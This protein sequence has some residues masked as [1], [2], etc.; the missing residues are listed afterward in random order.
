MNQTA[1]QHVAAQESDRPRRVIENIF[2]DNDMPEERTRLEEWLRCAFSPQQFM[3]RQM[4][5]IP[6]L[7]YN[8]LLLTA[9]ASVLSSD[10]WPD[11]DDR[12]NPYNAMEERWFF[13]RRRAAQ[14][15][16]EYFPRYLDLKEY[17]CP[18]YVFCKAGDA[19]PVRSWSQLLDQ[20]LA[21]AQSKKAI[22][23]ISRQKNLYELCHLLLPLLEAAYLVFVRELQ[24]LTSFRTIS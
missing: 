8:L 19:L 12:P 5:L 17:I 15:P 20:L 10:K 18:Q 2:L 9:A 22:Y 7:Q 3:E 24:Q 21:A 16:Y 6:R 11:E 1:Y 23:E 13:K 4:V 14:I